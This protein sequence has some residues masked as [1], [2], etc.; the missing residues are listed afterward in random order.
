MVTANCEN[1]EA[2]F[3]L[4]D[5]LSSEHISICTR[6]GEEGVN[7]DYAENVEDASEYVASVEG[8]DLSIIVY[9]G[10][11]FWTS[12][13]AQNAAWRQIGPYVRQYGIANGVASKPEDITKYQEERNRAWS[14]YQTGGHN[15]EETATVINYT[16]EENAIIADL[17]TSLL[18]YVDEF[19]A[20]ALSGNFDIDTGWEAY[21]AELDKIG[22]DNWLEIVQGAYDRMYK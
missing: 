6:W 4:G 8:F 3:R 12:P 2:A 14:L 15:P 21:L 13:D 9:D 17:E 5:C 11:V 18:N 19:K 16:T 1:P 22:V 20:G 7:W 10:D